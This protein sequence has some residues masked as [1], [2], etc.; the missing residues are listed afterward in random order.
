MARI[1]AT[2]NFSREPSPGLHPFIASLL[3]LVSR[4]ESRPEGATYG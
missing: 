3:P 4:A 1:S 2:L